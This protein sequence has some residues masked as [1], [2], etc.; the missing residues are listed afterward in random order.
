MKRVFLSFAECDLEKIKDLLPLL[1]HPECQFDFCQIKGSLIFD[2]PAA[3]PIKREIGK[4][5]VDCQAT[6][7]LI[8]ENTHKSKWVDCQ[9][10]KSRNKGNKIIAMAIKGTENALLPII[11]KEEN[12]R[13]YP[14]SPKKLLELIFSD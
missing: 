7:C 13:F 2:D 10:Y 14:W 3:E 11:I 6:V 5:I 12:L 4:K 1:D 9:L 8:A